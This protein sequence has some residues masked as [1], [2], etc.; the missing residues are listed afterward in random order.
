[1][2]WLNL[3]LFIVLSTALHSSVKLNEPAML[4]NCWD[5]SYSY[6]VATLV[7]NDNRV[8]VGLTAENDLFSRVNGWPIND[9]SNI[10]I[11]VGSNLTYFM[12]FDR[13]QCRNQGDVW[14]CTAGISNR[15]G[16][17]YRFF[18]SRA[19]QD[20]NAWSYSITPVFI[21][22]LSLKIDGDG[23]YASIGRDDAASVEVAFDFH[24]CSLDGRIGNTTFGHARF[25]ET[26]QNFLDNLPQR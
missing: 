11:T 20:L 8:E 25:P 2:R 6:K 21:S 13:E 19:V 5:G 10:P 1:M 22:K 23:I 17:G 24:Y 12:S 7:V 16:M 3:V 14:T 26:L 15:F 4:T 9:D 18:V